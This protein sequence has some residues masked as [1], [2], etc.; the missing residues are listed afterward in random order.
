MLQGRESK[1]GEGATVFF[2]EENR[3]RKALSLFLDDNRE[4]TSPKGVASGIITDGVFID[5]NQH[6]R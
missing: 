1:E 4:R 2:A 5:E 6:F 3:K